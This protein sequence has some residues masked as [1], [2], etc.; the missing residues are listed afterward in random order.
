[1]ETW[2]TQDVFE[3]LG[4][5]GGGG[6]AGCAGLQGRAREST[7]HDGQPVI[8]ERGTLKVCTQ[9]LDATGEKK[10]GQDPCAR[11]LEVSVI[12]PLRSP[13]RLPCAPTLGARN[14]QSWPLPTPPTT[15]SFPKN[16]SKSVTLSRTTTLYGKLGWVGHEG[17]GRARNRTGYISDCGK[18]K[19]KKIGHI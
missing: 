12:T 4:G 19:M 10:E 6:G 5:G 18:C 13:V 14:S 9:P 1:M 17:T 2:K 7:H 15:N 11:G 8:V 3:F 16:S